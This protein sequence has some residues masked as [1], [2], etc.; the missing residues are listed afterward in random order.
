MTRK[1]IS[2]VLDL[3]CWHMH[4]EMSFLSIAA[5]CP[6]EGSRC[7]WHAATH[8]LQ[9]DEGPGQCSIIIPVRDRKYLVPVPEIGIGIKMLL[10]AD[11]KWLRFNSSNK[12]VSD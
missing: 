1:P 10:K 4:C 5:R 12:P 3:L 6:P 8:L 7:P 11:S 2:P 9:T